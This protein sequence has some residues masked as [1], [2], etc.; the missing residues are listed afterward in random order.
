MVAS[1]LRGPVTKLMNPLYSLLAKMGIH[2]NMITIVGL[3]MGIVAGWAFAYGEFLVAA[4]AIFLSGFLDL[5]DGGVA[6]VGGYASDEGAF[7]DSF[8]DRLGESAIYIGL[9]IGFTG[10]TNQLLA[11]GIMI[12]SYSISYL[13]A[14][15]EG[16]GVSLAGIGI[17]ERAER[18]TAIFF[19]AI[20]AHLF[21]Q[22][23][24]TWSLFVLFILVAMTVIHRFVKVYTELRAAPVIE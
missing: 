19:A 23:I 17:M 12:F 10:R 6:R 15:G 8:A 13:R 9:V 18:M 11:L 5:L 14:R 22:T 21:G 16:L 3:G 1:Q 4:I 2:P 20:F 24:L 7:L